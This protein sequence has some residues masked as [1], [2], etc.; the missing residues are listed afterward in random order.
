MTDMTSEQYR[1]LA[2]L[3]KETA[4][5]LLQ[6]NEATKGD[7][8]K[9]C[10]TD[11]AD[12]LYPDAAN[13]FAKLAV[14]AQRNEDAERRLREDIAEVMNVP[15]SESGVPGTVDAIIRRV[16]EADKG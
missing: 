2:K 9:K 4:D 13:R 12:Q 16:R 8:D 5:N 1:E 14:Y 10:F 15:L 3:C 11:A 6:I 7:K